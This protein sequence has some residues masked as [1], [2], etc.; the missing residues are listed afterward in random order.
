MSTAE[1]PLP[2]DWEDWF[3][4]ALSAEVHT[5]GY[6]LSQVLGKQ[7]AHLLTAEVAPSQAARRISVPTIK[8][9]VP[10]LAK[11]GIRLSDVMR[12]AENLWEDEA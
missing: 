3:L 8:K 9:L 10:C 6:T 2:P 7:Y 11:R 1:I 4:E 5:H 12:R